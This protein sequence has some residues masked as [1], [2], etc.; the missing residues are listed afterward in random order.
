[1]QSP[2]LIRVLRVLDLLESLD[3]LV[4]EPIPS[5]MERLKAAG[6]ERR[7]AGRPQS[8]ELDGP[9]APW[10]WGDEPSEAP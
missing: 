8:G 1:M 10:R 3:R 5:P 4:P 6:R 9:T 7:R 2:S